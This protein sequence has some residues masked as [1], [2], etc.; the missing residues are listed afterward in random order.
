MFY[1]C[2][3]CKLKWQHPIER[4]PNCFIA[5]ERIKSSKAK[6]IGVSRV[7]ISTLLHPKVP[8]FALILE[9]EKGNKWAHKSVKEYKVGE[10]L[11]TK[12]NKDAVAIWRSKYDILEAIEK[13]VELIGG[14]EVNQK[15]KIIILPTLVSPAHPFIG[16]NTH[17]DVLDAVIKFLI[18]EGAKPENIKV[19]GQSFDEILFEASAQKSQFAEVCG[20]NKTVLLD[21]SKGEFIQKTVNNFNFEIVADLF[22]QDLIIN[23]PT[24]NLHPKLGVQGAT[25]NLIKLLDKRSYLALKYLFSGEEIF[26]K[27]NQVLP[28][29]ILTIGEAMS[30]QKRNKLTTLLSFILAGFDMSK[31]DRVFA[32]ICLVDQLPDYLKKIKIENIPIAGREIK[33]MQLDVESL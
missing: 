18:Q 32:E 26:A 3:K 28:S 15:S 27:I 16:E 11:H 4:C 33:E 30:V 21:L 19:A 7:T 2:P 31:V 24:L 1:Q 6:V 22:K 12:S 5:L 10:E 25:E 9:D 20:K 23:L 14:I 13:V 8:Y 17:P 29:N